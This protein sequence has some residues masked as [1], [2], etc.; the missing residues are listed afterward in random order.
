ML[1]GVR[2]LKGVI[3]TEL[4]PEMELPPEME[5][6]GIFDYCLFMRWLPRYN[7]VHALNNTRKANTEQFKI[8]PGPEFS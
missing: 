5:L 6:V 8:S 3:D 4:A 7:E 2:Q 1:S